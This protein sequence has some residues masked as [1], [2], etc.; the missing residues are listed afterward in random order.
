MA[1]RALLPVLPDEEEFPYAIRGSFRDHGIQRFFFHGFYLWLYP[2]FDGCWRAYQGSR[3]WHCNGSYQGKAM[4]SSSPTFRVL[5]DFLGDMDFKVW[6]TE[7]GITALQ[8][9]NKA[10][11]LLLIF[12]P[13]LWLRL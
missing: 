2:R 1:E 8:M 7:H 11:G 3:R 9:D 10:K 6:G 4:T 5:E 13:V 12:W